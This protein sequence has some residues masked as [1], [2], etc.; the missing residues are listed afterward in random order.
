MKNI[1]LVALIASTSAIRVRNSW[2]DKDGKV[3]PFYIPN[4]E[5]TYEE[6]Y[7]A[8]NRNAEK[9]TEAAKAYG[10]HPTNPVGYAWDTHLPKE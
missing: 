2:V 4:D 9:K 8:I 10:K 1:V 5:S 7:M 6:R 3:H